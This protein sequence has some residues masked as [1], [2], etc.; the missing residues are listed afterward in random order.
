[1]KGVTM[2]KLKTLIW[3]IDEQKFN[4]EVKRAKGRIRVDYHRDAMGTV[5]PYNV[6]YSKWGREAHI[7]IGAP[8]DEQ[9][10]RFFRDMYGLNDEQVLSAIAENILVDLAYD[11]YELPKDR[12]EEI[13]SC[14]IEKLFG[15]KKPDTPEL[16]LDVWG[17][18]LTKLEHSD[19]RK[20]A[21]LDKPIH[22]LAKVEIAKRKPLIL[23]VRDLYTG[24]CEKNMETFDKFVSKYPQEISGF[25]T[26]D[27]VEHH[28][29]PEVLLLFKRAGI[30]ILRD[31][32]SR[33]IGSL[34]Y[35]LNESQFLEDHKI[36]TK[37]E[38]ELFNKRYIRQKARE[39]R[40]TIPYVTEKF[41]NNEF[42]I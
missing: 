5:M 36:Y 23:A 4:G 35:R 18:I 32:E 42:Y 20:L 15:R 21:G 3:E 37:E 22:Q 25:I 41:N 2:G 6:D 30:D 33:S 17:V 38:L 12:K 9:Q 14:T 40:K 1:M 27:L 26:S 19:I 11:I 29:C 39:V 16:V 8:G 28:R 10:I 24:I 31:I 13:V 7:H 34:R